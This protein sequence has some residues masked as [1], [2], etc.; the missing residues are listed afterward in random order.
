MA[1]ITSSDFENGPLTDLGGNFN[2]IK[3]TDTLDTMGAKTAVSESSTSIQGIMQK[4]NEKDRD[5]REMGLAVS[6]NV[7]FFVSG[8]VDLNEG[9]IIEEPTTNK[10]WRVEA[11]IGHKQVGS[12]AIFISSVLKNIGLGS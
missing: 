11:I 6:G 3:V 7:K 12:N 9:D 4:I 5:I 1:N 10:R 2:L 8:S